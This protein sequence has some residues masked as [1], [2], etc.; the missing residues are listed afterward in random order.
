MAAQLAS[1]FAFLARPN[2][3]SAR[4]PHRACSLCRNRHTGD[5][6]CC[7]SVQKPVS[8]WSSCLSYKRG[9]DHS[10]TRTNRNALSLMQTVV[11][12]FGRNCTWAKQICQS[13]MHVHFPSRSCPRP[14]R[15][16]PREGE[17]VQAQ[18]LTILTSS[19]E[20]MRGSVSPRTAQLSHPH[21]SWQE[22]TSKASL[23]GALDR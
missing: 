22:P 12:S 8:P 4:R 11:M 7:P 20:R 14:A 16:C 18:R 17:M 19:S 5:M 10:N 9:R 21:H 2:R 6:V 3:G 23:T 15:C 13:T 1:L